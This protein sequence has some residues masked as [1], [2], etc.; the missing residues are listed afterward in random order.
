MSTR[1]SVAFTRG[2]GRVQ[3]G[4]QRN[5]RVGRLIS[6]RP[7]DLLSEQEFRARFH[8]PDRISIHLVNDEA[9]S[10]KKQPHNAMY[11]SNEQFSTGLHLPLL[12]IFKQFL[13]FTQISPTSLHSNIVQVLMGC[14]VLDMLF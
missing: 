4:S 6:E 9:L 3:K 2:G 8:I 13:H 12:S 5:T 14:S 7:I 10:S 11:F 1:E